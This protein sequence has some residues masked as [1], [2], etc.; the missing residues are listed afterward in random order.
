MIKAFNKK[1]QILT[2][3]INRSREEN[4]KTRNKNKKTKFKFHLKCLIH[5]YIC[6]YNVCMYADYSEK[7]NFIPFFYF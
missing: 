3:V 4:I 5:K 1:K 2:Q 6:M 7:W